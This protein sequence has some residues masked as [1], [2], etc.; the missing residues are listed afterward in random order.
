[1]RFLIPSIL[2]FIMALI[3]CDRNEI[4]NDDL[5]RKNAARE[6]PRDGLAGEWLF[7]GNV[8]DTSG[9][10]KN[11][12]VTGAAPAL[13][14]F[15]NGNCA[16]AFDG[17]DYVQLPAGNS[18]LPDASGSYSISIWFK[19]VSATNYPM[20]IS[21]YNN[22][23]TEDVFP[24]HCYLNPVLGRNKLYNT[25][26]N[27]GSNAY[28]SENFDSVTDGNWHHLVLVTDTSALQHRMYVDN[29]LV[30]SSSITKQAYLDAGSLWIGA[31]YNGSMTNYFSGAIDDARIY[32]RALGSDEISA[33]Y[34]ENS[35]PDKVEKP[36]FVQP[37]GV[38]GGAQNIE[39]SCATPGAVIRYTT[40]GSDPTELSPEYGGAIPVPATSQMTINARAYRAGSLPSFVAT[41][42][43]TTVS[44]YVIQPTAAQGNDTFIGS[45]Y[46]KD[47]ST[48]GYYERL[49]VGGWSDEY[50]GLIS[51][52]VTNGPSGPASAKL[53]L[54]AI[55]D[56][57]NVC[58][59][60]L[61]KVTSAWDES[62]V[63]W[64][65]RPSFSNV[66]TI[67]APTKGQWYVIDVTGLYNDWKSSPATNFGI[68]LRPTNTS[69]YFNNFYSSNI[70]DDTSLR[71]YLLIE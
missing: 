67:P 69:N 11:G 58:S 55:N 6:I 71:P 36:D 26:R 13:D 56:S 2:L 63:R 33:L 10:E 5:I 41:G 27:T 68:M 4:F 14:R 53:Y 47:Y 25:F 49:H 22:S 28:Y 61:E 59:M 62:S 38:Y 39:I 32:G 16:Y 9:N 57:S 64:A 19:A 48:S 42:K 24:V 45:V 17:N 35:W 70:I 12:L 21:G 60:Y 1:M 18:I 31:N 3:S 7:T 54:Y 40:D 66:A 44:G 15:G 29:R 20:V 34:H 23:G 65:T 30:S 50:D 37:G 52:D 8:F 46:D 51:F 43:Y